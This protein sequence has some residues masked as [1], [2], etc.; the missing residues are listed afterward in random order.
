MILHY[1]KFLENYYFPTFVELT[2]N[3]EF[4]EPKFFESKFTI[5]YALQLLSVNKSKTFT[6]QFAHDLN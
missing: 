4:Y 3:N 6:K 2:I 1:V 5:D